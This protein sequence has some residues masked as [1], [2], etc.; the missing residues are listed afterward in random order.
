MTSVQEQAKWERAVAAPS[1]PIESVL[2]TALLEHLNSEIVLRT[3]ASRDQ[4]LTWL[5]STFYFVQARPSDDHAKTVIDKYLTTLIDAGFVQGMLQ[6]AIHPTEY[7]RYMSKY[8]LSFKTM[9]A[10]MALEPR[11]TPLDLLNSC[12]A[13][14]EFQDVVLRQ[15]DKRPLKDL[16]PEGSPIK[17]KPIKSVAEKIAILVNA[18]M[19][20]V[21]IETFH[22]KTELT[23][24]CSTLTR[25]LQ[26]VIEVALYKKYGFLTISALQLGKHVEKGTNPVA[27]LSG[28]GTAHAQ[29]LADAGITTMET[30][31]AAE[32]RRI[33]GLLRKGSGFGAS[34]KTQVLAIPRFKIH[35]VARANDVEEADAV[36]LTVTLF[37]NEDYNAASALS[38]SASRKTNGLGS[39]DNKYFLIITGKKSGRLVHCQR[40]CGRTGDGDVRSYHVRLSEPVDAGCDELVIDVVSEHWVGVDTTSTVTVAYPVAMRRKTSLLQ[41]PTTEDTAAKRAATVTQ[42]K[43]GKAP[44]EKKSKSAP[45]NLT[46]RS[47]DKTSVTQYAVAETLPPNPYAKKDSSSSSKHQTST[48]SVMPLTQI[49]LNTAASTDFDP[50]AMDLD[51]LEAELHV[52]NA[53]APHSLTRAQQRSASAPTSAPAMSTMASD[54]ERKRAPEETVNKNVPTKRARNQVQ[55]QLAFLRDDPLMTDPEHCLPGIITKD[56]VPLV[57]PD[58]PHPMHTAQQV[59]QNKKEPQPSTMTTQNNVQHTDSMVRPS[60]IYTGGNAMRFLNNRQGSHQLNAFGGQVPSLNSST[61]PERSNQGEL[62]DHYALR[63]HVADPSVSLGP[64]PLAAFVAANPQYLS[65]RPHSSVKPFPVAESASI[66]SAKETSAPQRKTTKQANSVESTIH[67]MI[68]RVEHQPRYDI[69]RPYNRQNSGAGRQGVLSYLES[70]R[71]PP[72]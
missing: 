46:E 63:S 4:A 70:F 27:Q 59:L 44:K 45:E 14:A 40:F 57:M 60:E 8:Y 49:H 58:A 36:D 9:T 54:R 56:S 50:Y 22:L 29:A 43:K 3:V 19:A 62:S 15:S 18:H 39:S 17:K 42:G 6:T 47:V 33:E 72:V 12:A 13:M 24:I 26:C 65:G 53:H 41:N 61:V 64:N 7:G 71:R 31:L 52:D 25:I 66:Q 32:N 38:T 23:G 11:L 48:S 67:N 51:A 35:A 5:Q 20:G 34:L 68:R 2:E 30:L 21:K 1:E 37:R 16:L 10:I 69:A 28:I 55:T